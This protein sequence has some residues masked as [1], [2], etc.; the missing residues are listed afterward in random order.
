[1][2]HEYIEFV[3][4]CDV[5]EDHGDKMLRIRVTHAFNYKT[6]ARWMLD[7]DVTCVGTPG[8]C[9]TYRQLVI[10]RVIDR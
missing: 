2:Q 5:V 3:K 8:N 9:L 10:Y 7:V 1:M 6:F 4:I